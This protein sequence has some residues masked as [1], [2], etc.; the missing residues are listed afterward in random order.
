MLTEVESVRP[1][2][3]QDLIIEEQRDENIIRYLI[4]DPSK[5]RYWQC[6]AAQHALLAL[7]TGELTCDE[8]LQRYS[9][10]THIRLR[11]EQLDR[12]LTKLHTLG[13]LAN[14]KS[15]GNETGQAP[16]DASRQLRLATP[17]EMVFSRFTAKR[18]RLFPVQK[19][20]FLKEQQARWFFQPGA[21]VLYAILAFATAWILLPGEGWR[22][23]IAPLL[24]RLYIQISPASWGELLLALFLT[25][26]IH[27]L[28][29]ALTLRHFGRQPGYLGVGISLFA[30]AFCYVEIGEIWRLSSRRQR[31]AVSLAG[32]L[33]SLIAGSLGAL[34]WRFFSHN[35]AI[36]PW[37][38]ALMTAGVLTAI[39]NLFPF[40]RTDGYF[41]LTDWLRLPHL[42][43]KAQ[44]ELI[45]IFRSLCR[46]QRDT[47]RRPPLGQRLALAGYSVIAMLMTF[48]LLVA[49]LGLLWEII[50][51]VV[52]HFF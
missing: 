33:G 41:A 34:T 22:R 5:N 45:H 37:A 21:F 39:Y 6:G 9:A 16:P 17:G 11:S 23:G 46:H 1:R 19:L 12:V 49:I 35:Q 14:E 15:K 36:A 48:W 30:G 13:F 52:L 40:W 18:W 7:L 44:V 26:L 4:I 31:V 20:L 2:L 42:D 29:H 27:E 50:V 32:P 51:T 8:I 25:A 28:A 3:R 10:L 24:V 43:R 47:E 38:A